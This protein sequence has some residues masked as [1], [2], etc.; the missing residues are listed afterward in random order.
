[1]N[2]KVFKTL[3]NNITWILCINS[4]NTNFFFQ[5]MI[6]LFLWQIQKFKGKSLLSLRKKKKLLLAWF[7]VK[8]VILSVRSIMLANWFAWKP[9]CMSAVA[10]VLLASLSTCTN[11]TVKW[12]NKF[13]WMK[14]I[15]LYYFFSKCSIQMNVRF[16][17]FC[18]I[19]IFLIET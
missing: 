10:Q 14:E 17:W 6:L 19:A 7:L 4:T 15:K 11:Q 3:L 18:S 13:F 16:K 8:F 9:A 5:F 1:M 2:L 12:M